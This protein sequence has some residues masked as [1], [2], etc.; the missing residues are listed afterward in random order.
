MQ[1]FFANPGLGDPCGDVFP[2]SRSVTSAAPLR[3]TL[4][5]LL[6]GPSAAERAQGYQ[7]W[8]SAA[9]D[10]LLRGVRVQSGVAHVDFQ[11]QLRLAIPNASTSCGSTGLLAQLDRTARQFP[12]VVQTRY[13]LGGDEAA[14]Y[15][16]LQLAP[17]S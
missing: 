5:A 14:F 16:W 8:F 15:E 6:G 9:T 13:S 11:A 3:P 1:V 7:G 12:T 10:G 17:P 2:L 4:E